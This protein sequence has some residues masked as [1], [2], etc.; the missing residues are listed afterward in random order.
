MIG[1][2][3]VLIAG[4]G[5]AGLA[6][7][8][9]CVE[10]GF[11]VAVVAPDLDRPWPASY[12]AWADQLPDGILAGCVSHAWDEVEARFS[13]DDT[14]CIQRRYVRVHN[15]ALQDHLRGRLAGA[16]LVPGVARGVVHEDRGS[17][18]TT[19]EGMIRAGVVVDATGGGALLENGVPTAFQVAWGEI[20]DV[21]GLDPVPR[22]MDF[23]LVGD[24]PSF[25]YALPLGGSRWL[26][27]ET[28]LVSRPA[29]DLGLLRRQLHVRLETYGVRIR[30]VHGHEA[31]RIPMDVPLPRPQRVVGFGASAGMIHPSTGYLLARVLAAA[32][33]LAAA[34]AAH[35]DDPSAAS[36]AAWDTIWPAARLRQRALHLYG[37]DVVARLDARELSAFFRGFFQL[38]DAIVRGW[39]AD[40]LPVDALARAMA[41]L[42]TKLPPGLRWK[43]A[44]GGRLRHLVAAATAWP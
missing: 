12:G 22:W 10:A 1:S 18:V 37:A 44:S 34:L 26:L 40:D 20:A 29:V 38:P 11:D 19:S 23:T 43:V 8:A 39:L 6:A 41:S 25:L 5:P 14:N 27:E 33:E 35:R 16:R 42:F 32:P 13:S 7:A 31:V 30:A 21:D 28:S 17:S 4:S 2:C 36:N 15:G 24:V 3:D 9:S